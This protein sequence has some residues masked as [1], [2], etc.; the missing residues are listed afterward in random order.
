[1]N[2]FE[3]SLL[4]G[5]DEAILKVGVDMVA[6]SYSITKFLFIMKLYIC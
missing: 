3:T 6:V 1:M 4:S 2:K 5:P